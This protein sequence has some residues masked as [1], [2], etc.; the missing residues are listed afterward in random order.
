LP[1]AVWLV[2]AGLFGLPRDDIAVAVLAAG[3]PTGN[4]VFILAQRYRVYEGVAAS[5]TILSTAAA[6]VTLSLLVALLTG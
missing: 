1:A 3:L 5:A 6:A 4:N 2:A